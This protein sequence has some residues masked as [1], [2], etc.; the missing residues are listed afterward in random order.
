MTQQ[1]TQP[2]AETLA[3]DNADMSWIDIAVIRNGAVICDAAPGWL[4]FLHGDIH[5]E[6]VFAST[7]DYPTTPGL[8][9]WSGYTVGSW[10]EGDGCVATGG[11]F[12]ALTRRAGGDAILAGEVEIRA[13]TAQMRRF[14]PN[15]CGDWADKIDAALETEKGRKVAFYDEGGID[16][17]PGE[18][19]ADRDRRIYQ[20]GRHDA[21]NDEPEA[22]I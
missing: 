5:V 9:R 19:L 22:F 11:T 16:I 4:P 7:V 15:A 6:D 17:R 14:M 12:T 1:D 13:I 20:Q 2:P 3:E 8:Y 21:L 18:S 10:Q